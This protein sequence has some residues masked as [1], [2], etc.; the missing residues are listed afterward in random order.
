VHRRRRAG[1]AISA[2]PIGTALDQ[3]QRSVPAWPTSG[4]SQE[5]DLTLGIALFGSVPEGDPAPPQMTI[6]EATNGGPLAQ[7]AAFRVV[8]SARRLR[9]R[10]HGSWRIT[11]NVGLEPPLFV[12]EG[13]DRLP[14]WGRHPQTFTQADIGDK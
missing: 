6:K 3:Q 5:A 7:P 13:L 12:V 2:S 9:S 1:Y 8:T 14:S 4:L 11:A 10:P